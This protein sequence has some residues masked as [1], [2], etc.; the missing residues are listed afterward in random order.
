MPKRTRS[1]HDALLEHLQDPRAAAHYLNAALEDSDEMLLV[2]LRNVARLRV[3]LA[4]AKQLASLTYNLSG[5]SISISRKVRGLHG[6]C[7]MNMGE[8]AAS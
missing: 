2:A 1:H 3:L 5:N 6:M 4:T 8:S 7:D